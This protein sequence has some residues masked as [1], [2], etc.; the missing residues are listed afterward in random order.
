MGISVFDL[1]SIG[2]GPSS[3]HTVGP[4]RAA[5]KFG[6]LLEP[7]SVERICVHLYGSLA[8]TGIGHGTDLAVMLGL[9]GDSPES[10]DP[11]TIQERVAIIKESGKLQLM[12]VKEVPF[13]LIFHKD[14]QLPYHPNGMRFEAFGS[15]FIEKTYYSVGGGFVVTHG[16]AKEDVHLGD[17]GK[18]V[19]YPFESAD[20][21]LKHCRDTNLPIWELIMLNEKTW[22][23]EDQIFDGLIGI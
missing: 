9:E 6:R 8:L 3:S 10:V 21:L 22:R 17:G 19:P 12:G 18:S 20:V 16:E 1:F 2:V 23:S 7:A 15:N 11:E 13:E 14:K 4:M 5:L